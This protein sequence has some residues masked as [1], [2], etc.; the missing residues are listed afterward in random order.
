MVLI[1]TY[2][3]FATEGLNLTQSGALFSNV[4]TLFVGIMLIVTASLEDAAMRAGEDFDSTE[5]DI[6]TSLIFIA[7][8][9]VMAVPCLKFL[10]DGGVV[11]K[12]IA[13]I[14]DQFCNQEEKQK[15]AEMIQICDNLSDA[16]GTMSGVA[17]GLPQASGL[18]TGLPPIPGSGAPSGSISSVG[19]GPTSPSQAALAGSAAPASLRAEITTA[20]YRNDDS[21][22]VD[23]WP[24]SLQS[25]L[26]LSPD[27]SR[28]W[29]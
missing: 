3:P 10:S 1:I 6:I 7:N 11:D 15:M 2:R 26:H 22:V 25:R 12:M 4:L 18:L 20:R 14:S 24:E 19:V 23:T 29:A 13:K 5:R 28:S 8:M 16:Q 17:E 9:L 21:Q 27:N